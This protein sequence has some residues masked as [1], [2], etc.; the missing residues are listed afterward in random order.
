MLTA[1][2][3][4]SSFSQQRKSRGEPDPLP[5]SNSGATRACFGRSI[6]ANEVKYPAAQPHSCQTKPGTGD[7]DAGTGV[8]VGAVDGTALGGCRP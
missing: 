8:D 7:G 2:G 6:K 1:Q 5:H 4:S 3:F